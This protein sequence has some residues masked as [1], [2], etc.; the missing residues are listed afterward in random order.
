ME[1][2]R[3]TSPPSGWMARAVADFR[4]LLLD[5]RGT[6]RSTPVGPDLPGATPPSRRST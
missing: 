3:P 4:V 5:Q 2:T 1:A 6:G